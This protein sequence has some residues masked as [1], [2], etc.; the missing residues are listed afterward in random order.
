MFCVLGVIEKVKGYLNPPLK[1]YSVFSSSLASSLSSFLASSAGASVVSSS[2]FSSSFF[3]SFF[4]STTSLFSYCFCSTGF[5]SYAILLYLVYSIAVNYV[6]KIET[7]G[8][9]IRVALNACFFPEPL[10]PMYPVNNQ[11]S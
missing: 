9:F 7:C 11:F 8:L 4:S 1:I 3:S 6:I 5:S 10:K 2:F